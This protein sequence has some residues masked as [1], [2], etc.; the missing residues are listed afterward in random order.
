MDKLSFGDHNLI[1]EESQFSCERMCLEYR[2]YT[3]LH[4][5]NNC[6]AFYIRKQPTQSTQVSFEKLYEDDVM[7]I[8][9]EVEEPTK[10]RVE[11]NFHEEVVLNVLLVELRAQGQATC[12]VCLT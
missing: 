8:Y 9:D 10:K 2:K 7:N 12:T 4:L 5:S 1:F 6:K 11:V 3:H